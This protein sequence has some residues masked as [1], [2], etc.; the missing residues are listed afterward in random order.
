[1]EQQIELD[2]GPEIPA[3]ENQLKPEEKK[4]NHKRSLPWHNES[5]PPN[6]RG[7]L[8]GEKLT[9]IRNAAIFALY[10]QF[11]C[12]IAGFS[13]YVARRVIL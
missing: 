11:I 7:F 10:V 9:S 4:S 3:V 1:M 13:L 5:L 8:L 2:D 12:T 6:R